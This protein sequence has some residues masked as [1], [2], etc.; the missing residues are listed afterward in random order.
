MPNG[1][2]VFVGLPVDVYYRL[3]ESANNPRTVKQRAGTKADLSSKIDR[4]ETENGQ[5][6]SEIANTKKQ[7]A[8][9]EG[10][11]EKLATDVAGALKTAETLRVELDRVKAELAAA[12]TEL[13]K[14]ACPREGTSRF[15]LLEVE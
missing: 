2:D 5:H 12:K 1:Y 14:Y 9:C 7:L 11:C 10:R 6:R 3:C 13:S 8:A 4:L 15:A